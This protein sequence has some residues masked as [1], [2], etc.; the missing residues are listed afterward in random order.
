MALRRHDR[1]RRDVTVD[2]GNARAMPTVGHTRAQPTS[3]TGASPGRLTMIPSGAGS[4]H[5]AKPS[6]SFV[7][8]NRAVAQHGHGARAQRRRR[9]ASP[10][11]PRRRCRQARSAVDRVDRR[12]RTVLRDG[13]GNSPGPWRSR[14][15]PGS[16]PPGVLR[17]GPTINAC[18]RSSSTIVA[19]TPERQRAIRTDHRLDRRGRPRHPPRRCACPRTI[20]CRRS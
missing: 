19:R 10:L 8:K 18:I 12:N 16:S 2:R 14:P 6:A 13:P 5:R 4:R 15:G 20:R 11:P 9:S 7:A 1:V 3:T 17:R